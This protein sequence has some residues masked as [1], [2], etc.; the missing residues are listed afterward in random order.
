MDWIPAL[1]KHLDVSRSIVGA[2]FVTS[3]V[4][5][6]GPRFAPTYVDTV[7]KE[8]TVVLVG[9]LVF[10]AC[11]LL[12]WGCSA[13]WVG[14][15]SRWVRTSALLASFQLS[16]PEM[17]VLLGLGEHPNDSMN[18][19]NIDYERVQISRLEVVEM[20]HSLAKKGLIF[21]N[22]NRVSLTPIGRQRA[23]ELQRALA[24]NSGTSPR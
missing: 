10:S 17:D 9:T 18:I 3:A 14:A 24:N 19:E 20:M 13:V 16:Q 15:K 23:L 8:W 5:Y 2:V 12:F 6:A 7:P 11:L 22:F 4:L 21:F 1:L